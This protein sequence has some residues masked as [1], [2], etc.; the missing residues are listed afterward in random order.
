MAQLTMLNPVSMRL[1]METVPLLIDYGEKITTIFYKN[2]FRQH[3]ELLNLF[4]QT[5][6]KLKQQQKALAETVIG[7]AM[8]LNNL[9][10]KTSL[11]GGKSPRLKNLLQKYL[12]FM[13]IKTSDKNH[14][15]KNRISLAVLSAKYGFRLSNDFTLF[16]R[17]EPSLLSF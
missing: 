11:Q 1:V 2:L 7:A 10:A 14:A 3:P 17:S 15:K 6:Q 16:R 4:N 5:N 9:Q 12:Q 8:H 13:Q